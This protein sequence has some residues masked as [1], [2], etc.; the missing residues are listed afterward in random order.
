MVFEGFVPYFLSGDIFRFTSSFSSLYRSRRR[1]THSTSFR[2]PYGHFL[3]RSHRGESLLELRYLKNH[4][5][6]ETVSSGEN[7]L[8]SF[9][10]GI[11]LGETK[12]FLGVETLHKYFF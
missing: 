3:Y 2:C 5:E 8:R 12:I 11:V 7:E 6:D 4:L 9:S 10:L 1:N